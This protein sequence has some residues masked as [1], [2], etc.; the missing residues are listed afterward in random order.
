MLMRVIFEKYNY[1]YSDTL[2]QVA[3]AYQYDTCISSIC[4][5]S[6]SKEL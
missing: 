5:T 4:P 2:R 3:L 6:Q 1:G